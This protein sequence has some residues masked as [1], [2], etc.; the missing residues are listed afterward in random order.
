MPRDWSAT[1]GYDR[2][3]GLGSAGGYVGTG[4]TATNLAGRTLA[5]LVRL[6]W[7]D[8]RTRRW[9]PEPFRWLGVHGLYAAYRLADRRELAGRTTTSPIGRLADRPAGR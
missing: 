1:V 8:H 9:E 7:V 6:P 4:V 3:S 2:G 5:D